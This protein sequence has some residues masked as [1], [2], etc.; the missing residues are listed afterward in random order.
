MASLYW[1][2]TSAGR[3]M[4]TLALSD[5]R[6]SFRIPAAPMNRTFRQGLRLLDPSVLP[7]TAI[8]NIT[9]PPDAAGGPCR[10]GG[11]RIQGLN[12]DY[13]LFPLPCIISSV[14]A[15]H[16]A[17]VW[18]S[19]EYIFSICRFFPFFPAINIFRGSHS[20]ARASILGAI[21]LKDVG[22]CVIPTE[23]P[24]PSR[25]CFRIFFDL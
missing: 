22:H 8:A 13:S 2:C 4:P 15:Q 7:S 20:A 17:I 21:I 6:P 12:S 14:F 24:M 18:D 9:L 10:K 25:K 23:S 5:F 11:G 16:W 3:Q 19:D 1:L